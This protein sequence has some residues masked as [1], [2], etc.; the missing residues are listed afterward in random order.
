MWVIVRL[1]SRL[2]ASTLS[3]RLRCC[4]FRSAAHAACAAG[5]SRRASAAQC[6]PSHDN[7]LG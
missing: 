1:T 4:R 6:L 7:P 5:T 2:Q 3:L